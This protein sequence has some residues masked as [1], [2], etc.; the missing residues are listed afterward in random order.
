MISICLRILLGIQPKFALIERLGQIYV[1]QETTL[2]L[3][4]YSV[5]LPKLQ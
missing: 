4:L 2:M 1:L 3:Y 5:K